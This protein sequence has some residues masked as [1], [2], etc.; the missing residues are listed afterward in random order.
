MLSRYCD[1]KTIVY[2]LHLPSAQ[3]ENELRELIDRIPESVRFKFRRQKEFLECERHGFDSEYDDNDKDPGEITTDDEVAEENI[4]T[5]ESTR[6]RSS[7]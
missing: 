5:L 7:V 6:A 2:C 1:W 3:T 4:T